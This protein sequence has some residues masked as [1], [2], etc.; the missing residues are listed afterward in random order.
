[1]LRQ[2]RHLPIRICSARKNARHAVQSPSASAAAI[3]TVYGSPEAALCMTTPPRATAPGG[4]VKG[5]A[6]GYK[7]ENVNP[8]RVQLNPLGEVKF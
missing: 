8:Q 6:Y 4:V 1:M 2:G 7:A 3:L 5:G